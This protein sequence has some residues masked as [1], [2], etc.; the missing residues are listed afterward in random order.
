VQSNVE[1][2]KI[3][4]LYTYFTP[5]PFREEV[6]TPNVNLSSEKVKKKGA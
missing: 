5:N 3:A 1:Y 2:F 6:Y 4:I